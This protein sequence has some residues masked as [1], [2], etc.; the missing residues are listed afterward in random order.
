[1]LDFKSMSS[2]FHSPYFLYYEVHIILLG[3]DIN[4]NKVNLNYKA[5]S[6]L[7]VHFLL[8]FMD[9]MKGMTTNDLTQIINVYNSALQ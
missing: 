8:L 3:I 5:I 2:K 1:M 4:K 7:K 6:I 9:S